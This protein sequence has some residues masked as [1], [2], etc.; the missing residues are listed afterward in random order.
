MGGEGGTLKNIKILSICRNEKK[1]ISYCGRM[2]AHKCA[3]FM[4]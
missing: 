3:V 4:L 2:I 1:L